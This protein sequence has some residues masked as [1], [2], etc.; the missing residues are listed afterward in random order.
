MYVFEDHTLG[1]AD[2]IQDELNLNGGLMVGA[3]G[4]TVRRVQE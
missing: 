2:W 1:L 3:S 4:L